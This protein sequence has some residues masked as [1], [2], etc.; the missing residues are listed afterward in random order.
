M[1][2]NLPL[3]KGAET[4]IFGPYL[5]WPNGWMDQDATWYGIRRI[6]IKGANG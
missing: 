3:P 2:T 4:A 6:E 5:S 1:G